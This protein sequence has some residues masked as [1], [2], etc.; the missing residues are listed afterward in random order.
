MRIASAS[1]SRTPKRMKRARPVERLGDRGRLVEPELAH[2]ADEAR[3]IGGELRVEV[4]H[5]ELDDAPFL[6]ETGKVDEQME[7]AAAQRLRQFARAVGGQHDHR[8]LAGAQR[9][10]FGNRDL[11]IGEQLEQK[12]L[13]LL[14]GLVDLVDQQDDFARRRN[15]AQ[16][17]ALEQVLAR[18]T[19]A[20]ETS[21]QRSP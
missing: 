19:D 9:A 21:S 7:A 16:Q 10:E 1:S 6:F 13:E 14:V 3:G 12:G 20:R 15:R 11:E 17:R 5:L 8:M 18:E 2:R 4:R